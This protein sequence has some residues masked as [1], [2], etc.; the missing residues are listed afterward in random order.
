MIT[1]LSSPKP[2]TGAARDNQMSA[3]RS[4]LS[5]HPEAEVILYGDS[6]G[7]A[8]VCA[9][10]GVKHVPGIE[11]APSGV[12]YFGA[13][14]AHAAEHARHDLQVYLNCDILL[15]G[16]LPAMR[17][18]E[19]PQFLLIGQRIDLGEGASVDPAHSGWRERLARLANEGKAAL[20]GPSAIDYF[21]FRRGV[22]KGLPQV[23]IG[24]AGYDNALLAHC[25]RNRI[26]V[27]DATFAVAALHQYHDYAHVPGG[28]SAVWM[29]QDAQLNYRSAGG[30][31]SRTMVSDAD[32]VLRGPAIK[33]WPCRGDRLRRLELKLRYQAGWPGT[34]LA[35][36]LLWRALTG[37]GIYGPQKI[38]LPDAVEYYCMQK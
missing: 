4:W 22:W 2:F 28:H 35:L 23:V 34:A 5:V 21:G 32:Y 30:T 3:V 29:G 26:P 6:A 11:C 24:R 12:P 16:I 38:E 19:F 14:A 7:C 31:H 33:F 1:F 15:S 8:E 37:L 9:G 13:I 20:H 36:R 25:F 18:I 17:L 10:L 27:V